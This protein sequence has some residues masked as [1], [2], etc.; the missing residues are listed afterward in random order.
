MYAMGVTLQQLLY[1]F[2]L[3]G[4]EGNQLVYILIG[5]IDGTILLTVATDSIRC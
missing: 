3:L 1:I 4:V 2:R 5:K